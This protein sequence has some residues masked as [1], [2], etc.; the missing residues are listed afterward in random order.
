MFC[1]FK[2]KTGPDVTTFVGVTLSG[3]AFRKASPID[4][5]QEVG[6]QHGIPTY[7]LL[8]WPAVKTTM[9]ASD[10]KVN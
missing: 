8:P 5:S 1:S 4:S 7:G 9:T 6:C 3:E 2:L 10:N